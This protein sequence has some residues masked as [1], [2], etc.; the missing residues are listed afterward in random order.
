MSHERLLV[1]IGHTL[2]LMNSHL[3]STRSVPVPGQLVFISLS[4]DGARIAVGTLHERHTR[5][6]HDQLSEIIHN[7]PEEDID[8]QLFDDNFKLLLTSYQSTSLPAP[9]LS[10]D[11]EIRTVLTGRNHWRVVEHSWNREDHIIANLLSGCRPNIS[12]PLPQSLFIVGCNTSPLR[13]WYRVLRF[14][15]HPIL[16]DPGSSSEMEQTAFGDQESQLAVRV[17]HTQHAKTNGDYFHRE[18]L[19]SQQVSVFRASDGKRLFE[20]TTNASLAEQSYA[21]SPSGDRLAVLSD[22]RIFLYALAGAPNLASR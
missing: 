1:H 10:N 4:P 6:L 21:L 20:I 11:G 18:D 5:E 3:D 19:L 9:V 16:L 13:N 17:I 7:E 12:T 8:I 22:G 14:D 2:Y 15:G